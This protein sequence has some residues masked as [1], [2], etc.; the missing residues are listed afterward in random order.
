MEPAELLDKLRVYVGSNIYQVGCTASRLNVHAQQQRAFNLVWALQRFDGLQNRRVA[1]IGGGI[2]G[3]TA[4]S[5]AAA[6]GA[7]V[8]LYEKKGT[9]M[10]LQAG[11]QTRFLHP[12]IAL[13]PEKIVWISADWP[14]VSQL[15]SRN[16]GK[17][18]CS[19]LAAMDS[20]V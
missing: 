11:N 6:A 9:L 5:A 8:W 15:E 1:I 17:C 12:S 3:I 7:S 16:G 19:T 20:A 2:A 13:W 14:A 4:A 10:H 18:D